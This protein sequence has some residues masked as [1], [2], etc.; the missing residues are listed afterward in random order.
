MLQPAKNRDGE[1]RNL[2]IFISYVSC[3]ITGGENFIYF[4]LSARYVR[5]VAKKSILRSV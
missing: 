1:R 5:N 3:N 4:L 2:F